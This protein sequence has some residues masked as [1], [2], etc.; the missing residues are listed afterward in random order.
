MIHPPVEELLGGGE[1]AKAHLETCPACRR[2]VSLADDPA[3]PRSPEPDDAFPADVI[4]R[5]RYADWCA[6]GEGSGAMGHLF[7]AHD[8][9]IGREVVIKQP[10]GRE[11]RARFEREALLTARLQHPAIVGVYE[12]GRFADGEPFYAMPLVR[13]APLSDE[14]ARR[15]TPEARLGLLPHVTAVCEAVAYAHDQGIVHRDLKPANVLVGSFGETV[16]IDWGL[17]TDLRA[18]EAAP[19]SASLAEVADGLTQLGVGTPQYMPPEQ[20]LGTAPDPRMDVYSLG[21]TLYHTLAGTPP[22]AALDTAQVRTRLLAEPPPPLSAVAPSVAPALCDIV[23]R[24]MARAPADRFATA[25]DL[26]EELRRFQTGQL[27]QSRRYS[28]G[29]ILRHFA[30][31]YRAPL[32]V[33]AVAAA[34][35]AGVGIV[36][37]VRVTRSGNAA[38]AAQ[39]RA[40]A[41]ERA[42]RTELRRGMGVAASRLALLPTRRD[43][44]LA[45]A[46][47]AVAPA[48]AAGEPPVDEARQGLHDAVAGAAA[49][50]LEGHT[51]ALGAFAFSPDGSRLAGRSSGDHSVHLWDGRSGQH[52]ATVAAGGAHFAVDELAFSPDGARLLTWA[53]SPAQAQ[54]WPVG[55]DGRPFDSPLRG[56]AQDRPLTL[57]HDGHLA[58]AAFL[59]DGTL[60]L[61]GR[62]ISFVDPS[63]AE[64]RRVELAAPA[65]ALASAA[66]RLAVATTSGEVGLWDGAGRPLTRVPTGAVIALAMSPDGSRLALLDAGGVELHDVTGAAVRRRIPLAAA[67]SAR[68]GARLAYSASGRFLVVERGGGVAALVVDV[69]AAEPPTEMMFGPGHVAGESVWSARPGRVELVDLELLAPVR[70]LEGPPGLAVEV[71]AI[72]PDQRIAVATESAAWLVDARADEAG[73]LVGHGSEVSGLVEARQ[74][75]ISAGLDGRVLVWD[76]AGAR[77]SSAR[78]GSEAVAI[79][80]GAGRVVVGG[81]DGVPYFFELDADG[82]LSAGAPLAPSGTAISALAMSPDG[83]RV[84]VGRTDGEL[85]VALVGTTAPIIS[86]RPRAAPPVTAVA[87]TPDGAL[88][89]AIHVTGSVELW[90]PSRRAVVAER[91]LPGLDDVGRAVFTIAF[92]G[93]TRLLAARFGGGT[94]VLTVPSLDDG[95]ALDGRVVAVSQSGTR[96][97]TV[98]SSGDVFLHDPGVGARRVATAPRPLTVAALSPDSTSLAIGDSDGVVRVL[99]LSAAAGAVLELPAAGAGAVSALSFSADGRQLAVGHTSG[100][101]R[102][103][104]LRPVDA[105]GRACRT[106]ALLGRSEPGCVTA[107]AATGA[108]RSSG[109]PRATGG[110]APP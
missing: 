100:V 47:A 105:L 59:A 67:S 56:L 80:T 97:A 79:A 35:L 42:S 85:F 99:D 76:Q 6:L 41:N 86:L 4:D 95:G 90:D 8:V 109:S 66:D 2:V 25:R 21:A 20:A 65:V 62:A 39:R 36:S 1:A 102:L 52:L 84:A 110:R 94:A 17:G 61:A 72:G 92:A 103:H 11:L 26:A 107:A 30:R 19:T 38:H 34:L 82:R 32:A 16:V 12:V 81:V 87:F 44:A 43:E 88:L 64:I 31:R 24:A 71:I 53:R 89:A 23:G 78:I 18:R 5:G 48:I 70:A 57:D 69:T 104:P 74:H 73:V 22:Y 7:R 40:E 98:G 63:G 75:L 3:S 45:L 29:E 108:P 13:G 91:I 77:S 101:L 58:G 46:V 68:T 9:R 54:L 37:A 49:V 60:V 50:V 10:R 15:T 14:I 27:V 96:V 51:A 33:A 83:R 93:S 106:L 55:V 28:P